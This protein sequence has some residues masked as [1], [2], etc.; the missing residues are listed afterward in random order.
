[1]RPSVQ[2]WNR[3]GAKKFGDRREISLGLWDQRSQPTKFEQL[4][5]K[6]LAIPTKRT[7]ATRAVVNKYQPNAN[8][9]PKAEKIAGTA[10]QAR[11]SVLIRRESAI[12]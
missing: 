2:D 11:I 8:A 7:A 1:M 9:S 6:R 5:V 10:A 12:G 4:P 3:Y